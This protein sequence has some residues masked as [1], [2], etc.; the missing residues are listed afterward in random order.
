MYHE[1]LELGLRLRIAGYKNVLAEKSLAYHDYQFAINPGMFAW[2]ETYR[3]VVTLAYWRPLT[4]L[5]ISPVL[6]GVELATWMF[7]VKGRWLGA[8]MRATHTLLKPKTWKLIIAMRMRMKRLR[9]VSDRSLFAFVSG[10]IEAQEQSNWIVEHIAN[11]ALN[12]YVRMLRAIIF[13]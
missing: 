12:A 6:L 9:T 4:L 5:L 2:T 10:R 8:K 11:P 13:W 7:A 3:Y 1:D